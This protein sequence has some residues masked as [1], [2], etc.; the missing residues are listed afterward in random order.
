MRWHL[1]LVGNFVLQRG[2][3]DRRSS[4]S[5]PVCGRCLRKTRLQDA[6]SF[7]VAVGA[8]QRRLCADRFAMHIGLA[9]VSDHAGCPVEPL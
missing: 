6:Q 2:I 3:L 7:L 5:R 4:R 1:Q 8:R 9:A